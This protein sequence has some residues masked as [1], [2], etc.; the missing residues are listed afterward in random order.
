MRPWPLALVVLIAC[1]SSGA[2]TS[3]PTTMAVI[4]PIAATSTTSTV[5]APTTTVTFSRESRLAAGACAD[6]LPSGFTDGVAIDSILKTVVPDLVAAQKLCTEAERQLKADNAPAGSRPAMVLDAV[7]K[8]NNAMAT[9][10]AQIAVHNFIDKTK[11]PNS[12]QCPVTVL[13]A[14]I[15]NF[16][17]AAM[18]YLG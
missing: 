18:S 2:K 16:T 3:T 8:A 11:C 9:A 6:A 15:K 17:L 5:P 1:G 7:V 13:D 12:P 14:A 4:T 10:A